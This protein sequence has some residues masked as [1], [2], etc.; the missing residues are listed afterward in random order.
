MLGLGRRDAAAAELLLARMVEVGADDILYD[1]VG[2]DVAGRTILW[3]PEIPYLG[4]EDA[5]WRA[6][7]ALV[8]VASW[9]RVE[10][11]GCE[12]ARDLDDLFVAADVPPEQGP[13]ALA[14]RARVPLPAA[15]D[16][17]VRV[18]AHDDACALLQTWLVAE[19]GTHEELAT[20]AREFLALDEATAAAGREP[21]DLWLFA[22]GTLPQ[23]DRGPD[24]VWPPTRGV[25][26][27]GIG[28]H[29]ARF[30]G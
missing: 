6:L 26:Y 25:D 23:V 9:A 7:E 14:R 15:E 29:L 11:D 16:R 10:P 12:V 13:M 21:V 1:M 22:P 19:Q 3:H 27:G 17:D 28:P 4:T 5:Y 8:Q 30:V 18:V 24:D 20:F 2:V